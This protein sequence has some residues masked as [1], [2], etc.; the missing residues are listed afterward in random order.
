MSHSRVSFVTP[1]SLQDAHPN[2]YSGSSGWRIFYPIRL[3]NPPYSALDHRAR[4][5]EIL[6]R[7]STQQLRAIDALQSDNGHST[8]TRHTTII[9]SLTA[10]LSGRYIGHWRTSSPRTGRTRRASHPSHQTATLGPLLSRIHRRPPAHNRQ[11]TNLRRA[12]RPDIPIFHPHLR[13]KMD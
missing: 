8:S 13:H 7:R 10:R 2:H 1:L 11:P 3:A 5:I 6:L 4:R 9:Q 12:S